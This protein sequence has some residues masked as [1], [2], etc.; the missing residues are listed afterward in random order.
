M[1]LKGSKTAENLMSAFSGESGARNKYTFF[2][3]IAENEG[4]EQIAAIFRDTADNEKAHAKMWLEQLGELGDTVKNLN[5]AAGGES[6]EWTDMYDDF[7][8]TAE[9]EGFHEIA[10]LFKMVGDIEKSHEERFKKL[11]D[12]VEMQRVF[13]KADEC[14]WECRNCGHLVIGKK[15]PAVCPVCKHPQAFFQLRKENY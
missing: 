14:M 15:A 10:G 9:K 3:E 11:L 12:N 4:Y 13:E 6:Y 5:T 2:A 7:A 1:E 8:A